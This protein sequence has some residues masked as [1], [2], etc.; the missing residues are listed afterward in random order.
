M[1]SKAINQIRNEKTAD[2]KI[3]KKRNISNR[4]VDFSSLSLTVRKSPAIRSYSEKNIRMDI[5]PL[6]EQKQKDVQRIST[7]I[8]EDFVLNKKT[9][10]I[11]RN[12]INEVSKHF[13][14]NKHTEIDIENT[15]VTSDGDN[16][17]RVLEKGLK[18]KISR[19]E[20]ADCVILDFAGHTEYYTTH[21]TFLTTNAVYL[22]TASLH[23][24][25]CSSY[26]YDNG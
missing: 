20:Y 11:C 1:Q 12:R 25:D 2:K 26:E 18:T 10:S 3:Y 7:N 5:E 21:Q 4:N 8:E 22:I 15:D 23:D 19:E 14:N 16:L 9:I 17:S 6:R 24:S 13:D